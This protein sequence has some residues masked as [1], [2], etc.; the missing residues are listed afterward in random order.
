LHYFFW[1]EDFQF[2]NYTLG[3]REEEK[4][5]GKSYLLMIRDKEWP[6]EEII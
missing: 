3:K 4:I 1:T 6:E 5:L 2:T